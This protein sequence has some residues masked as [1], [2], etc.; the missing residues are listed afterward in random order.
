M[1]LWLC[2]VLPAGALHA[3][4]QIPIF[5]KTRVGDFCTL[6]AGRLPLREQFGSINAPGKWGCGYEI[7]SGRREWKLYGPDLN[8]VYG[9]ANGTGGLE[10]VSPYLNLF[11]PTISDFRGNILGV[12]TNSVVSWNPARPTGYGAVP[13]YRP[14]A[15]GSGASVSLSSA[16]RGRWADITGY[17][18]M[19][20]RTYDPVSG[21]WLSFDPAWNGQ[22]PNGF[23]MSG[24]DP[25]NS[26]DHDGRISRLDY[27]AGWNQISTSVSPAFGSPAIAWPPLV[28]QS[29]TLI[30][31]WPE[32][33]VLY[34]RATDL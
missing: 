16:W 9:G 4:G 28:G 17:Y 25:I 30:M 10:A 12:V 5:P 27:L 32:E 2:G 11:E 26:F 31:S 20:A 15:L 34:R 14:M 22:D 1:L 29:A 18:G 8:G 21:R 24:G 3:P 7:V 33:P 13:G 19:G 23:S 6:P